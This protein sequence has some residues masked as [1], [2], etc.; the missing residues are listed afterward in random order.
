MKNNEIKVAIGFVDGDRSSPSDGYWQPTVSVS[1]HRFELE[2]IF[3]GKNGKREATKVA[4]KVAKVLGVS[5][6]TD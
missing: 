4:S 2:R 6:S 1:G 5:V 3:D